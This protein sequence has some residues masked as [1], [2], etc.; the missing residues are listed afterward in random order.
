MPLEATVKYVYFDHDVFT[1]I[2]LYVTD[3]LLLLIENFLHFL[4]YVYHY[5]LPLWNILNWVLIL[6]GFWIIFWI[7][8]HHKYTVF[9]GVTVIIFWRHIP[10]PMV[11]RV[12][13][14]ATAAGKSHV[15]GTHSLPVRNIHWLRYPSNS[16]TNLQLLENK[17]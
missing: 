10:S 2:P 4:V 1:T 3:L 13:K 6:Q 5:V 9:V 17:F 8:G 14:Q 7:W 15:A 12:V 16:N 11:D